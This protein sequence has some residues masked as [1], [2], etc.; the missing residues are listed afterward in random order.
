LNQDC[1]TGTERA[2]EKDEISCLALLADAHT[3]C[4]HL[5]NGGNLHS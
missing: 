1:F 3:K 2:V 4:V 5:I